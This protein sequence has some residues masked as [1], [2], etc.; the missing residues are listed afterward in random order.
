M[1][2]KNKIDFAVDADHAL[3]QLA[4]S[5]LVQSSNQSNL[6]HVPPHHHIVEETRHAPLVITVGGHGLLA[7]S[8]VSSSHSTSSFTHRPGQG[9]AV[10]IRDQ[11][12]ETARAS[13]FQTTPQRSMPAVVVGTAPL[14]HVQT[15]TRYHTTPLRAPHSSCIIHRPFNNH[16]Q[17]TRLTYNQYDHS[18]AVCARKKVA[19]RTANV[20]TPNTDQTNTQ[21]PHTQHPTP[22]SATSKTND[23]SSEE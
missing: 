8:A 9:R 17:L 7:T 21:R 16:R 11:F 20:K 12:K 19:E 22:N 13:A 14:L 4:V 10:H 23:D 2:E 1:S 3:P 5:L 15:D 6:A 18:I